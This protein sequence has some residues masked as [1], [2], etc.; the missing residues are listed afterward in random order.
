MNAS[1]KLTRPVSPPRTAAGARNGPPAA[2]EG[3]LPAVLTSFVGRAREVREVGGLLSRARLL[4]LVG[5]GG[6]G[7]TRLALR[8][9][10]D[11]GGRGKL[12]EAFGDGVRWVGLS[13]LSDPRLVPNAAA[14]AVGAREASDLTPTEALAAF[15][16]AREALLVM[17]NCEHL[18]GACAALADA[19]LGGCPGLTILATSREPLGVAGEVAWPV[20]PLSLP[21]RANAEKGQSSGALIRFE[22]V[23][24]F[25]ERARAA[26]PGFALTQENAPAVAELCRSLDGMPLAIELAASMLRVL[27]PEQILHRLHDR[28]RLLRGGRASVGRHKTL[29]ATIDWSHDL[30]SGKEKVLFRRLSVFSGGWTLEAAEEVCAGGEI[31]GD[32]VLELLSGLVDKSLVVAS[33]D[34]SA[35]EMRYRMLRTIRQYASEKVG[36]PVEAKALGRRHAGYFVSLAEEAEPEMEGLDQAVWLG[37][38]EYEHDNIRAALGWLREEGEAERGLRLA[39]ALVRFWWFRGH[40]AE[41]RA[42]LEGLLA[43]CPEAPVRDEVHARALQALGM[44]MLIYRHADYAAGGLNVARSRLEE[45][46]DIYRRLGDETSVAAV[47]QSLG[48][49]NAELGEWA[50][51]HSILDESLEIGRRSDNEPGIA[52]SLFH[53][54]AIHFLGGELPQA[55]VHLE[56]SIELFRRLGDRF[57][58]PACLVFLGYIDCEEGAYAVARSRFVETNEML[59]LAQFPWGATF[60]L[61]GFARLATAEG[62][63]ARALRLAGATNAL[64]R[65]FG[66]AVGLIG[67]AA[68][69]RSMEP[70]WRALDEQEAIAAWEKGRNTTLEDAIAFALEEPE[71]R[72]EGP[73]KSRL[74]P[75]EAEVLSLVSEGLSDARVAEEL[76]LSPRTVGGHLRGAY[77]KLGVKSRTAA[78]RKAGELGLI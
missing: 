45:G 54:G 31:D 68:F 70:A 12:R 2:T 24:L 38:L 69:E 50:T 19:L 36:G 41:G 14:S 6:C 35:E 55:R 11:L 1:T 43:L 29:R 22:S 39:T 76:Y 32:G 77:R 37:R 48:R 5:P 15:L 3:R 18:V 58:I 47:L 65:T 23:R 62:Q 42:R 33:Q 28:F 27:S 25:D 71:K 13:S 53:M 20:P 21:G 63:A 72:R 17:D 8:V 74:T 4:T 78:A 46:L 10:A 52:L 57:W 67:E 30:L 73:P 64:R 9:A 44:L 16:G 7:K 51:A 59:P 61:E 60:M 66:V 56:E 26:S 34:G 75:R 40:F 49:V